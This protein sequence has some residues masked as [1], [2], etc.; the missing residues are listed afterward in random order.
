M[1]VEIDGPQEQRSLGARTVRSSGRRERWP[2]GAVAVGAAALKIAV[3][4]GEHRSSGRLLSA[5]AAISSHGDARPAA[6]TDL[7]AVVAADVEC[8][9]PRT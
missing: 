2:L 5:R 4:H 9:Q 8:K 3:G 1:A 7:T 6:K